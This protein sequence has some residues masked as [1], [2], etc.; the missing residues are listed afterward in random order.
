[1]MVLPGL[2]KRRFATGLWFLTVWFK[3]FEDAAESQHGPPGSDGRRSSGARYPGG[4]RCKI[5]PCEAASVQ[6]QAGSPKAHAALPGR[7]GLTKTLFF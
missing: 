3:Y 1:M 4:G 5:V 7:P 2:K 6:T